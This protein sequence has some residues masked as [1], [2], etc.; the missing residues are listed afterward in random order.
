MGKQSAD[1]RRWTPTPKDVMLMSIETLSF[2]AQVVL[3]I[4]FY[5]F[6]VGSG[7]HGFAV[8]RHVS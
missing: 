3:C 1:S 7:G 2:V 4:L 5:N 8:Q 6:L